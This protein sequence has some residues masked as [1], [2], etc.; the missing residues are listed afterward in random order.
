MA[1]G[2]DLRGDDPVVLNLTKYPPS[3]DF[4]L[5]TLGSGLWLLAL[6]E[7]L[8]ASR[9]AR[10]RVFGGAPLFFYLLHLWLLRGLHGLAAAAG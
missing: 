4:L 8:P 1:G 5:L 2:A 3:A 7:A 6:F 9:L 10:L